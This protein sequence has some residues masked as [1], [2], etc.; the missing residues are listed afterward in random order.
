MRMLEQRIRLARKSGRGLLIPAILS[1]SMLLLLFAQGG[2]AC[3]QTYTIFY[4]FGANPH[5][6]ESPESGLVV[7]GQGHLYGTTAYGGIHLSGTIFRLSSNGTEAIV[8]SFGAQTSDGI[9]PFTTLLHG[10]GASGFGST[11]GGGTH[12]EGTVYGVDP[13]GNLYG[14]TS[15]G[16]FGAGMVF[17]IT[18]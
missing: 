10:D 8:H 16:A 6:G 9:Y 14:T 2:F 12:G 17:K 18:P 15:G 5:D 11:S 3:A 4:T 1:L 7:D 13:A